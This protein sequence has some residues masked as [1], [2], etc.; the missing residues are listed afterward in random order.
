MLKLKSADVSDS[1][2]EGTQK[3]SELQLFKPEINN[4]GSRES[5][6]K[7]Y[8]RFRRLSLQQPKTMRPEIYKTEK[9]DT[10]CKQQLK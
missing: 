2:D 7:V 9:L 10:K 8:N 6:Q 4:I 1:S 3:V 5:I